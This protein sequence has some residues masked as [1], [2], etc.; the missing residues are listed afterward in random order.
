M[1]PTHPKKN[2]KYIRFEPDHNT[3]I[4]IS[5]NVQSFSK[6]H[7]GLVDGESQGGSGFTINKDVGLEVGDFIL[8]QV[9]KMDTLMA[10]I[11]WCK[12]YDDNLFRYG[13]MYLE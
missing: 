10:E 1:N 6:D 2:R 4:W 3:T 13:V 8:V 9:G 7:L 5:Q 12:K 11:R